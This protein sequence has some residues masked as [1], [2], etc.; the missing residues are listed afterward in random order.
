MPRSGFGLPT[1]PRGSGF[2]WQSFGPDKFGD[3]LSGGNA[4]STTQLKRTFLSSESAGDANT[5]VFAILSVNFDPDGDIATIRTC[6]RTSQNLTDIAPQD[7]LFGLFFSEFFGLGQV[8]PQ[9]FLSTSLQLFATVCRVT[10]GVANC[11]YFF[12]RLLL[13]RAFAR[14][15]FSALLTVFFRRLE[16]PPILSRVGSGWYAGS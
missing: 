11:N 10:P 3:C 4:S 2:N 14:F 5:G 6:G 7:S 15:F 9:L 13:T 8:S 1:H 12:L 16:P